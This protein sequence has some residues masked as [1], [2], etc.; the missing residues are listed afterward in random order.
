MKFLSLLGAVLLSAAVV[1]AD[2]SVATGADKGKLPQLLELINKLEHADPASPTFAAEFADELPR[3]AKLHREV[4][5]QSSDRQVRRLYGDD[6]AAHK[7]LQFVQLQ[8]AKRDTTKKSKG[9]KSDHA[10]HP[11]KKGEAVNK[12][13]NGAKTSAEHKSEHAAHPGNKGEAVNKGKNGAKKSSEHKSEHAAH[14]GNKGEAVN[15]GKNG[16]KVSGEHKLQHAAHPHQQQTT[17]REVEETTEPD[18]KKTE[19]KHSAS[20]KTEGKKTATKKSESKK[21]EDKK[22]EAKKED[23]KAEGKKSATEHAKHSAHAE[24]AAHAS[25]HKSNKKPA[26]K[27]AA[28]SPATPPT[29]S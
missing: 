26:H 1:S 15:K 29:S 8:P 3:L 16:Q 17:K 14:P 12:G 2:S 20:K 4:A 6:D 23:K 10:A 18:T 25:S 5:A 28:K 9:A 19:T 24:H 7:L 27:H 22:K 21:T 11:A 13:K